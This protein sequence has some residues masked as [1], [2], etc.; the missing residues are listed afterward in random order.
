MSVSARQCLWQQGYDKTSMFFSKT[1]EL[2]IL[3]QILTQ[4]EIEM[5]KWM[6]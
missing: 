1:A 4:T 5:Q 3:T 2:K 6:P